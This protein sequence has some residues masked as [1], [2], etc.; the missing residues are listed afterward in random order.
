MR[1]SDVDLDVGTVTVRY[2]LQR[3]DGQLTLV[4]PKTVRGRRTIPLPPSVAVELRAHRTRQKEERLWM[5]SRWR[6]AD[7]VFTTTIGTPLDGTNV[8]HR[9]QVLL[10]EAGLPRYRFHDLRHTAASLMLRQGVPARVV[11]ETLGHSQINLTLNTYSHVMPALMG[12]AAARMDALL[13]GVAPLALA[14]TG[15][16]DMGGLT[17]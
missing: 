16:A 13:T 2:T 8:T 3:V 6:D 5:G 4:E 9:F 14:G 7:F 11:M 12:D 1:W 15:E 17:R 10:R